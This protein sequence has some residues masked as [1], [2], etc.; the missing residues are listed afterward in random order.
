MTII[1]YHIQQLKKQKL[2]CLIFQLSS[3]CCPVL[4]GSLFTSKMEHS[5]SYGKIVPS[6]QQCKMY[7][8]VTIW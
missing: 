4:P 7:K 2:S 1:V 3:V 5:A 8:S 6:F